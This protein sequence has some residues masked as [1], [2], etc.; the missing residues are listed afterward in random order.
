MAATIS[1]GK[2]VLFYDATSIGARNYIALAK[3]IL[4]NNQRYLRR[5]EEIREEASSPVNKNGQNDNVPERSS[6]TAANG[7][8]MR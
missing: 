4:L 6:S 2:P 5:Y 8:T 7:F 1:F 3:E